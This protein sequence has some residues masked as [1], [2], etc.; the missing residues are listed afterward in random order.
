MKQLNV[1]ETEMHRLHAP[2]GVDIGSKI[3][4]EIAISILA[5][6]IAARSG[7]DTAKWHV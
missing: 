3:P 4:A 5:E 6:I 7:K 2:I 1:S